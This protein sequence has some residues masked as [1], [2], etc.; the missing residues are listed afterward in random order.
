MFIECFFLPLL[1]VTGVFSLLMVACG[2]VTFFRCVRR[3]R[4]LMPKD[5]IM[6]G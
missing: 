1:Y 5:R 6:E 3:D 2:V 4:M